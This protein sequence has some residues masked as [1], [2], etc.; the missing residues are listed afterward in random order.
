MDITSKLI[1]F[2]VICKRITVVIVAMSLVGCLK[3]AQLRLTNALDGWIGQPIEVAMKTMGYPS[4]KLEAPNGNTVYVFARNSSV[5]MPTLTTSNY[6]L[7]G[8]SVYGSSVSTG[9]Q[10]VGLWC[11]TYIEVDKDNI[12]KTWQFEGNNCGMR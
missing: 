10:T 3:A 9:G 2:N 8:G 4:G 5:T 11:R 1:C 6:S 12:I 7:S